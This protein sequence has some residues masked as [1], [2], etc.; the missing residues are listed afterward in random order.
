MRR[1]AQPR[2][3]TGETLGLRNK[4]YGGRMEGLRSG[5]CRIIG[6]RGREGRDIHARITTNIR[7]FLLIDPRR[8]D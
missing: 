2:D 6:E 5:N 3:A 8:S 4:P 1:A 7:S